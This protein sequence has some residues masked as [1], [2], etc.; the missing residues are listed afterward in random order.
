MKLLRL[1][2][3]S[4]VIAAL[5][6]KI[7]IT[8]VNDTLQH[9][10][11]AY[12]PLLLFL[13]LG[14]L[15]I[16]RA[17]SYLALLR[18][19][20]PKVSLK[21]AFL[22]NAYSWA[23]GLFMPGGKLGEFSAVYFLKKEGISVEEGAAAVII[24]KLI[25]FIVLS[26]LAAGGI[27]KFFGA[28]ASAGIVLWVIAAGTGVALF[29]F[30]ALKTSIKSPLS[31][32][33]GRFHIS[34]YT[35]LGLLATYAK[36]GKMVVLLNFAL[37]ALGAAISAAI[38]VLAFNSFGQDVTFVNVLLVSSAG[39]LAALLPISIGGL[40]VRETSA[41]FLFGQLG[42]NTAVVLSSHILVA[43]LSYLIAAAIL[44]F[45]GTHS[46]KL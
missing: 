12:L 11:L 45:Y 18:I 44:L 43:I 6:W 1:L 37:T 40:G 41:V 7:G 32:L 27:A 30:L 3:G 28:K 42:V 39:S 2:I 25:S 23:L 8:R 14:V 38:Y 29:A 21:T 13:L 35:F 26:I 24:D 46:K 15:P 9:L 22:A 4:V 10:N 19:T 20:A 36:R 34:L 5:I 17:Y 16:V 33:L 31:K